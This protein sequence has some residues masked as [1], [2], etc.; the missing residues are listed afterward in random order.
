MPDDI[1]PCPS[2]LV[3]RLR[4]AAHKVGRGEPLMSIPARPEHDVDLICME[5]ASYIERTAQ[6]QGEPVAWAYE[7]ATRMSKNGVYEGWA[8]KID[9]E[10]PSV[11]DDGI[12][13][14]RPLFALNPKPEASK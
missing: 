12:R 7:M 11:P 13:N 10:K 1:K 5:A 3:K 2:D 6:A 9:R 14:L 4:E 8:P